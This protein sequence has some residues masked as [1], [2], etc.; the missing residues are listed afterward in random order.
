MRVMFYK[1][2]KTGGRKGRGTDIDRWM[3]GQLK[4]AG[5]LKFK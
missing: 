2:I 4:H 5:N 3:N 1:E